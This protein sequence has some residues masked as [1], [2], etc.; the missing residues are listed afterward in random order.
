MPIMEFM[1]LIWDMKNKCILFTYLLSIFIKD[2]EIIQ[3]YKIYS[4][5][6]G[7]EKYYSK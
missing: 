3:I 1:I 5:I 4:K 6:K 2:L 7:I